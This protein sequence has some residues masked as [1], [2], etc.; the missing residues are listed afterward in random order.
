MKE[1]TMRTIKHPVQ[2]SGKFTIDEAR[3]AA[4]AV[5]EKRTVK[6]SGKLGSLSREEARRA[7]EAVSS[8]RSRTDAPDNYI[9]SLLGPSEAGR[10]LGTSGQWV[11]SLCRKGE[12]KAYRTALGWLIDPKDAIRYAEERKSKQEAKLS[13][14]AEF[15]ECFIRE[16]PE[17]FR[18]LANS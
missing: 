4:R 3:E 12:L 2:A 8:Q 13:K 14:A 7:V 9:E 18:D 15:A 16:H 1:K 6:K 11:T 17:T 5:K 10:M